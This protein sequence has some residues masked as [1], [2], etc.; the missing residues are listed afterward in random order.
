MIIVTRKTTMIYLPRA[1]ST[2]QHGKSTMPARVRRLVIFE[3]MGGGFTGIEFYA[4]SETI[5]AIKKIADRK[6]LQNKCGK[7]RNFHLF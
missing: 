3:K 5:E 1:Q 2:P 7:R 4:D 6:D